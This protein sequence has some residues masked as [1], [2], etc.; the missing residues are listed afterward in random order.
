MKWS[1][2]YAC[3]C[4]TLYFVGPRLRY[5][6][7]LGAPGSKGVVGLP[8]I[9]GSQGP[10]GQEGDKGLL[11]SVLCEITLLLNSYFFK[12]YEVSLVVSDLQARRVCLVSR[13]KKEILGWMAYRDLVANQVIL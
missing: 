6:S 8:G 2:M 12:V 9:Q 10:R 13:V 5:L 11:N 1:D 3:I 4:N 7:S